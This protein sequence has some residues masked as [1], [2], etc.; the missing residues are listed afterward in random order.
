MGGYYG[1]VVGGTGVINIENCRL[2]G[3]EISLAMKMCPMPLVDEYDV[4]FAELYPT[5][6]FNCLKCG[7]VQL[8][9]VVDADKMFNSGYTYRTGSSPGLVKHF[10]ELASELVNEAR[11]T[12][13]S[14]VVDIGCND[15]T[16]L[17]EI[18]RLTGC[19]ILGIDPAANSTLPAFCVPLSIKEV[20]KAITMFGRADLVIATNVLGHV[21][22]VVGFLTLAKYLLKSAGI[23]VCEVGSGNAIVEDHVWEMVYHE[24]L[25]YFSKA[26]LEIALNRVG[27][28]VEQIIEL[29]T[30]G[31]SIRAI[32]SLIKEKQISLPEPQIYNYKEVENS[33]IQRF[34]EINKLSDNKPIAAFGASAKASVIIWQT[35]IKPKFVVDD[36][37]LKQ[38]K[39]MPGTYIPIVSR[40]VL[41]DYDGKLLILAWNEAEAIMKSLPEFVG[42]FVVASPEPYVA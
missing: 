31:G 8:G 25:S 10:N 5:E 1:L 26:T 21:D 2:C 11:L 3:G 33:I 36:N 39:F 18:N 41:K 42:R 22:D 15:G 37:P 35:G 23:F 7:L 28:T 34:D 20:N 4:R 29:E 24:H 14:F 19:S 30:H 12:R 40:E 9:V 6:L 38:G 16:L 32:G 13:D 17:K 27:F